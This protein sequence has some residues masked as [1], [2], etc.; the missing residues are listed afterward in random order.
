ML[1][2]QA[3][4][5]IAVDTPFILPAMRGLQP[6]LIAPFSRSGTSA[7]MTVRTDRI[8]SPEDF[9]GKTVTTLMGTGTHYFLRQFLRHHGIDEKEVK[10]INLPPPDMVTAL[11][12]GD[13]DAMAWDM[14]TGLIAVERGSGNVGFLPTPDS[15]SYWR[16][17][18]LM[19]ARK[20]LVDDRPELCD[21]ISMA[22]KLAADV[23]ANDPG[24][25]QQIVAERTKSTIDKTREGMAD[26]DFRLR[27]DDELLD[28]LVG[29]AEWQIENGVATRPADDLRQFF[30]DHFYME[31]FR[32]HVPDGVTI[33]GA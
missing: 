26:F 25:A 6:I 21:R 9:R 16:I 22:L 18:S 3:D 32:K 19:L 20:E 2:G 30:L 7:R 23:I 17:H 8:D 33:A 5:S 15:G 11:A 13:V 10:T 28:D 14:Q 27:F 24:R 4:V 1:A 12:R 29:Q 31:G